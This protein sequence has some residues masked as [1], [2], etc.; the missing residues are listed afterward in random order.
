MSLMK[1][2]FLPAVVLCL[3]LLCHAICFGVS[4]SSL[5][6]EQRD[7]LL[8]NDFYPQ[9]ACPGDTLKLEIKAVTSPYFFP[10]AETA[11]DVRTNG[12]SFPKQA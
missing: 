4:F 1:K 9:Y 3:L 11:V 7:A 10:M 2:V 5:T 6:A 8:I 12:R